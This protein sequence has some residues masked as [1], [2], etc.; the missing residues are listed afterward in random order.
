[1]G[2]TVHLQSLKNRSEL[3]TLFNQLKIQLRKIFSRL[4]LSMGLMID[5]A[6]D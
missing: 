2:N 1:M 5:L 3:E 4:D 6:F